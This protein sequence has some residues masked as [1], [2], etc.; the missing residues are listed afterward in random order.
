MYARFIV[1]LAL[2]LGCRSSAA[3]EAPLTSE[4]ARGDRLVGRAFATR[5]PVAAMNGVAATAHPLASQVAVDVLRRGGT[6]V[7]AA[8][9]ANAAL[10]LMEPVGCGI[11]GDLF[12][13]VWDPE[14]R[15]LW[16]LNGS[17]RSPQGR[18]LEDLRKKLGTRKRIPAHGAL[19][20]TVPGAVDGWFALHAR[21]GRL[22]MAEVLAPAIEY[23]EAGF[24][25]T[26]LIAHYWTLNFELFEAS[27]EIE[28]L[29][30]ARATFLLAGRPPTTGQIFKNP[31]LARTYRRIAEGG[32]DVFYRGEIAE[33]IDQYMRRIGGDLRKE[34]LGDHASEWVEPVGVDY[35][36]YRVWELP[37]NGQGVVALQML[38]VIEAFDLTGLGWG[39][40]EALH[41][42]VEAKRLAYEDRAKYYA[43]PHFA[44]L[45]VQDLVSD[46]YASA[47]R[48]LIDPSRAR[49]TVSAGRLPIDQGDTTYLTVADRE[50][51][52]VSLIQ[53]NYRGMGSGLVP[54]QLGFMLQ[55]RGEMFSLDEGHA[56][57]YAPGK[58]PFHT[59]IPAFVTR[60]GEPWLSFGVMGGAMQ[61]Q[62]HV[63]VLTNLIDFGMNVQEA[64]DAARWRHDG[65][66][67]P[68]GEV[69]E[70]VGTLYV[71]SGIPESTRRALERRGHRV[72]VG[73]G[74][75]GGYQ[76]IL[77]DPATGTWHAASE[78][79]KD[80]AAI[81]F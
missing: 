17:G 57:V 23:A 75:F 68:T 51:M 77:R 31:D 26:P 49:V 63:Q 60:D 78:M 25:V 2:L 21:F 34:D 30:N 3:P 11:G 64:G 76:A 38:K 33:T 50:G 71:E 18:T 46:A 12:A 19:P 58:R 80:G 4:G 32:R 44:E 55:D 47:R 56:N 14:T 22:P 73:R 43:D 65:S 62:G 66:S 28:E 59:I 40:P 69:A 9:A 70:G 5:S 72:E 39:S 61:P 37:P 52:M 29:D 20:V 13:L 27:S 41:V 67:E 35:R 48:A 1:L 16:G 7:D 79:R 15:R 6:A 45:P 74:G 81:G 54:D 53:S 42:M 24:P 8:V 10:G 36:G